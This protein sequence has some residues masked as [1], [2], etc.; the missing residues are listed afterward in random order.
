[1]V[2]PVGCVVIKTIVVVKVEDGTGEIF[3]R[4]TALR[5]H[6]RGYEIVESPLAAINRS[7]THPLTLLKLHGF[8]LQQAKVK[9]VSIQ[10]ASYSSYV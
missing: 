2:T 7:F 4:I 5:N 3:K 8:A 10:F 1:M 9:I 6:F